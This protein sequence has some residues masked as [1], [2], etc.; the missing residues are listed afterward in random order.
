MEE[1]PEIPEVNLNDGNN[2]G[3]AEKSLLPTF[4]VKQLVKQCLSRPGCCLR[5]FNIVFYAIL[6]IVLLIVQVP[7]HRSSVG[8]VYGLD[9]V[10]EPV[11][12]PNGTI[13]GTFG[14][15]KR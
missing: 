3:N 15:L 14:R 9:E 13:T 8:T 6:L 7:Q 2:G 11:P 4:N 10:V 5:I 1:R 12:Q